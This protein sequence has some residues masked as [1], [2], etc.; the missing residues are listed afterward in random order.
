MPHAT[1]Y[2]DCRWCGIA[3]AV[4]HR[5]QGGGEVSSIGYVGNGVEIEDDIDRFRQRKLEFEADAAR[6]ARRIGPRRRRLRNLL[7]PGLTPGVADSACDAL[8][9]GVRASGGECVP[10]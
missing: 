3:A 7:L 6:R 4:T 8:S 5:G 10:R 9:P 2:G 1:P